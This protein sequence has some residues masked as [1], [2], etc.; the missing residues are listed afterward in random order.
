MLLRRVAHD[1]C[2]SVRSYVVN[3]LK[4][5]NSYDTWH[6]ENDWYSNHLLYLK[7]RSV[8]VTG[9][10]NVAKNLKKAIGGIRKAGKTWFPELSDKSKL[11]PY[12][13]I[14]SR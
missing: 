2:T 1:N 10:K 4:L 3:D 5:K 11:I 12:T 14:I 8:Y 9:T 7:L 6:G 13:W